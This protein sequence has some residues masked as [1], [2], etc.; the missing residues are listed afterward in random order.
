MKRN[1]WLILLGAVLLTAC[2]TSA[3]DPV[4]D[5]ESLAF[6][7][8][9]SRYGAVT[10]GSRGGLSR[11]SSASVGS[12]FGIGE[13]AATG[14]GVFACSTG[15]EDY[16]A[17][18]FYPGFM[19]DQLV[20]GTV[21]DR[22]V[23]WSYDPVKYWPNGVN[24]DGTGSNGKLSF[25]AYAPYTAAAASGLVT[26]GA[27]TGI[28]AF[29]GNGSTAHPAVTYRL[30]QDDG[31][32]TDL[33]WGR[34]ADGTPVL[35]QTKLT[36][37]GQVKFYFCHALTKVG[38][39]Q[40][41]EGDSTGILAVL[42]VD[43]NGYIVDGSATNKPSTTR[44]TIDSLM[45]E[46]IGVVD[47]IT[48]AF[49]STVTTGGVFDLCSGQWTFDRTETLDTTKLSPLRHLL[50]ADTALTAGVNG[51]LNVHLAEPHHLTGTLLW[52]SVPG[53]V[54][55]TAR[56][57]YRQELQPMLICPVA[58]QWPVLRVR[59]KTIVRTRDT[60]LEKGYSEVPYRL[61]RTIIL[62]HCPQMS[63]RYRLT[64]HLGIKSVRFDSDIEIWNVTN[65]SVIFDKTQQEYL[66]GPD[67]KEGDPSDEDKPWMAKPYRRVRKSKR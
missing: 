33:L 32:N 52:D 17:D 40:Q 63:R 37:G 24:V 45:I 38:G 10:R 2:S 27:T 21:A 6:S 3:D 55:T 22:V 66:Q 30:A 9:A 44:M 7:A 46:Q 19:Y 20:S 23:T 42:D 48:G 18:T 13:L 50:V 34:G 14:F 15:A 8:Y 39:I 67:I 31:K 25:F 60:K 35:N 58:G 56:N 36:A 5:G 16:A 61:V 51:L 64:L 28:T 59:I 53:G 49:S 12:I 54:V 43:N 4:G 62:K 65:S 57:V 29:T 11:A 41:Q 1:V 26:S 47:S